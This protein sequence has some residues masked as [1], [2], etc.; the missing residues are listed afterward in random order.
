MTI[1][2]NKPFLTGKETEYI[3]K[4]VNSGKI[5]GGGVYTQKCQRFFED[6][7]GIKKAMLTTSC[8]SALEMAALL[9]NL[10]VGDEIIA[11]SFTFVSTVNAFALH[12]AKII[13]ADS[14]PLYPNIDPDK[15]ENLITARTRAIVIVHYGGVACEMDK[16][17]NLAKKYKLIVI[18]D[19]AP[20]IGGY[21]KSRPLGSFGT[22]SAF[23]FHETKNII[24]G[25]GGLLGINDSNY[26]TRAEIIREKGTNR[27]AFLRE[28]VAKYEWVD[29]GSSYLPSEIIAAFLY[30]QIENLDPIQKKRQS[31]WNIYYSRLIPLIEK[32]KIELPKIPDYSSNN[33]HLFYLVL[34]SKKQRTLLIDYL[35]NKGVLAVFHYLPLHKSPYYLKTNK[36]QTLAQAER[37]S[38][39]LVRLPM[40]YDLKIQQVEMICNYI[41]DFFNKN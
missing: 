31:L 27:S 14:S 29:T 41:L 37:Y 28:E 8:T 21:Y 40:Y 18:E 5:S 19:A 15:L 38:D 33:A 6:N 4:A 30:A 1:P 35:K 3:A 23:S 34:N 32:K 9:L 36:N 13:F 12:G 10:K 39:C 16:I 22:F 24:C 20:A 2:F 26:Q 17:M 11:P 25:E 7:H